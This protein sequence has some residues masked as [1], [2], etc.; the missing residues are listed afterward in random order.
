M[1]VDALSPPVRYPLAARLSTWP[2]KLA[3][4]ALHLWLPRCHPG[5]SLAAD[6]KLEW[7]CYWR[8]APAA[9]V[10]I[11]AGA[12]LRHHL[13][14][15]VESGQLSIGAGSY[16]GPYTTINVHGEVTIGRDCLIAEMVSIRDVDH[17][18]ADPGVPV[19]HQGYRQAP[20][21]I[22][23]GVWL[24]ARVSVLRGVTIGPGCVVGAQS[25]VTRDL[26]AGAIAVGVP[27]RVI[28]WRHG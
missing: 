23:D 20:T 8:I 5:L 25:V 10:A 19:A 21:R 28:G 17:A 9:R 12:W 6:A 3:N 13:E 16:V 1:S 11:G 7:P 26:P 4:R 27:A 18:F 14:L 2:Q 22:G 24:G 15:L